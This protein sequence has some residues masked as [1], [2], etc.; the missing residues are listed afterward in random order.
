M[1]K[2]ILSIILVLSIIV[3]IIIALQTTKKPKELE[4]TVYHETFQKGAGVSKVNGDAK[5]EVIKK[6][7]F[8]GNPNGKALYVSDRTNDWD[9][10]DFFY[11]DMG[12]EEN[13]S[14]KIKVT[15]YVDKEVDIPL[16]GQSIIQPVAADT[17][18]SWI[19]NVDFI[20]GEA[21]VLEGRFRVDAA[22]DRIRIQS[23]QEGA[24]VPFYI[25]NIL[26]TEEASSEIPDEPENITDGLKEFK[27]ITFEDYD[28]NGFE[29]RGDTAELSVTNEDNNTEGG[30]Y[31]LKVENRTQ[32]WHGPSLNIEDY[33]EPGY[34]YKISLWVKLI[35]P[36]SANLQL[37]TQI[38]SDDYGPSYNNLTGKMVKS[39]N[40][41]VKF[42]STYRYEAVADNYVTIYVESSDNATASFYID[43]IS[44]ERTDSSTVTIQ[45]DLLAIKDAY[46]D[47]FLIGNAVSTK[48]FDGN[49]I[50]LLKKHFNLVTA[51]NAMKPQ[52]A[53]NDDLEFDFT[54]PD[55]L[56]EMALN[57]DFKIHGHVLVWHQQS[58]ES[59]HTDSNGN[60]LSKE[61]ALKNL[62]THVKTTVEHY[63]ESVISW[64]VVNEAMNDNPPS[65]GNWQGSLRDS[66]WLKAIGPDYIKES[67][68]AA[69]EV[70]DENGWDIP[71]YYNDYNDD[72]KNKSEAIYNM[73][74][75][76]N[77]E[78]AIDND[79]K[80]LIS[81]VGMQGHY[82]LNTNPENVRNSLEKFVSL[83]VEVG[84]TELDITAGESGQMTEKEANRQAFLYARL[85]QLYKE[86][87]EHISRVTLWGLDD[88]ASWRSSQNPLLFDMD[89]QAK[90]AYYAIIDPDKFI[91]EYDVE[92]I[93]AKT[94]FATQGTPV[95][96]GKIDDIWNDANVIPISSAQQAWDVSNGEARVLWDSK[97][98]YVLVEVSDSELD[99]SSDVVHEQDSA[100]VFIDE[101]NSKSSSYVEGVVQYR[102][103]YDNEQTFNPGEVEG[104]ESK[105]HVDKS[106]N[107]YIVEMKIPFKEIT[108]KDGVVIG[109][110]VQINDAK[111]GSRQG[112]TIWNDLTGQ[113][114]QDPSVF[115][116]LLLKG[117]EE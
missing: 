55:A 66:G 38:G 49:R 87:A 20:A 42:E 71:L 6:K 44:F 80:K 5:L 48:E 16:G 19:S 85:F 78:Y 93:K 96:D 60:P 30:Q 59:L 98:L 111:N 97:Y 46:K 47:Y 116:N 11:N 101:T 83:G 99:K 21:I 81:G 90:P 106:A 104:F 62:R 34:E 1:N 14:Y 77:E 43:D 75:E 50:E 103:N 82:N 61:E 109:F 18:G 64:D 69:K 74:K 114:Y 88:G 36:S 28:L 65:P 115:G 39:S 29:V 22:H 72:N 51:E 95:I 41:W 45:T 67:F 102:I 68:I 31:A 32:E 10:V 113:G 13:K 70:I 24:S 54:S 86:H 52:Y 57:N 105:T 84:I 2:K 27:T 35:S 4:G 92:V 17:Y 117:S 108:P 56:V 37:S 79:G 26:I 40:G 58:L 63:G 7:K 94:S 9:A 23:N 15:V 76:I 107:G 73:V 3:V 112:V 25:G 91:E 110:D 100:E 12:L 89:L 8:D 53:Y 33:I